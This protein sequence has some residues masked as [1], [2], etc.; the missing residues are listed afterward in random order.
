MEAAQGLE[1]ALRES[2]EFQ[3]LKTAYYDLEN[4]ASAKQMFENFRNVQLELQQ[5]QMQGLNITEEEVLRAQQQLQLVQQHEKIMKL[6]EIEQRMSN[7][8]ND[9]N[10]AIMKPL[11]ELY[12]INE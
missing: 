9:I 8:I 3:E 7:I 6:M 4:D 1:Q 5:K 12:G 10:R 2:A 11:E